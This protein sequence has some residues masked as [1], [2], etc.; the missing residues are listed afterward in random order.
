[1]SA[2]PEKGEDGD[3]DHQ[4]PD[5]MPNKA[6]HGPGVVWCDMVIR[7]ESPRPYPPCRD[8]RGMRRNVAGDLRGL[9]GECTHRKPQRAAPAN[10]A[11]QS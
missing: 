11:Q 3:N 6:E 1:M 7:V 9:F 10:R 2:A 4:R 8:D 5:M